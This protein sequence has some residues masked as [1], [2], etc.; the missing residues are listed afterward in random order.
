MAAAARTPLDSAMRQISQSQEQT[1]LLRHLSNSDRTATPQ[2]DALTKFDVPGMPVCQESSANMTRFECQ[3]CI[4]FSTG[5]RTS[6]DDDS[7]CPESILSCAPHCRSAPARRPA[8]VVPLQ[9]DGRPA[10]LLPGGGT[11]MG[12]TGISHARSAPA[13][14]SPLGEAG[15]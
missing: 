15:R 9:G 3:D 1:R 14:C 4:G 13:H 12:G 2:T 5:P 8:P 7:L 6:G 10:A 11:Q